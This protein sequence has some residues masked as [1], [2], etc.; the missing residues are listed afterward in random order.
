MYTCHIPRQPGHTTAGS[1]WLTE[2]ARGGKSGHIDQ[3]QTGHTMADPGILNWR[4]VGVGETPQKYA[5]KLDL[6]RVTIQGLSIY[7]A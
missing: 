3:V 6:Q 7:A 1:T 4:R 2:G 5:I